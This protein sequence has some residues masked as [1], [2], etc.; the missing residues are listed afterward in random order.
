MENQITTLQPQKLKGTKKMNKNLKDITIS[1]LILCIFVFMFT[2]LDFAALHDINKE[3]VSQHILKYLKIETSR[4]LPNWTA[5][6]GEWQVVIFSLFFR[7]F[8]FILN[9]VVL[10]YLYKK[11]VSKDT[12][13]NHINKKN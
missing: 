4:T 11:I 6:K 7:F 3:Y 12:Y 8:F 5:T 10:I 9:I 2:L 1:T 13:E